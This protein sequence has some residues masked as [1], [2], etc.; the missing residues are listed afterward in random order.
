MR[1]PRYENRD[2]ARAYDSALSNGPEPTDGQFN[3]ARWLDYPDV[4]G[5]Q[6][7]L[8]GDLEGRCMLVIPN[9]SLTVLPENVHA[10]ILEWVEAGGDCCLWRGWLCLQGAPRS[11]PNPAAGG[12]CGV[13]NG[14]CRAAG[15]AGPVLVTPAGREIFGGI[16]DSVTSGCGGCPA[17]GGALPTGWTAL[18]KDEAGQA[19]LASRRMAPAAWL[20]LPGLSRNSPAVVLPA[21]SIRRPCRNC[22]V[23][24]PGGRGCSLPFEVFAVDG[25]TTRPAVPLALGLR[26]ARSEDRHPFVAGAYDESAS[27]VRIVPNPEMYGPGSC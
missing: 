5:E 9:S 20:S 17:W 27:G 4:T 1:A 8:D 22:S 15:A 24:W 23:H 26:R 18:L 16:A 2:V 14:L 10:R 3:W 12:V 25:Q 11:Q 6:L 7:V 19:V 13:R 21:R